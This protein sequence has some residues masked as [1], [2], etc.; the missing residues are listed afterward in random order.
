MHDSLTFDVYLS[1]EQDVDWQQLELDQNGQSELEA[2]F[3]EADD[4]GEGC[5][6][7]LC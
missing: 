5:G 1:N 7:T 2:I 3:Q 6:D 4:R